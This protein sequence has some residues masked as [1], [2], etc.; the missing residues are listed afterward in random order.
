MTPKNATLGFEKNKTT[1]NLIDSKNKQ[2]VNYL[3][4]KATRK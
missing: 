2:N 1:I 3:R 4:V